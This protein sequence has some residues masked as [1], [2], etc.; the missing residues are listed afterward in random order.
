MSELIVIA[1]PNEERAE[2]VR[3]KLLDL[4]KSYVI[5]IEDAV[6]A[7]KRED[8]HV[9]LNQLVNPT[10]VSAVSGGFWGTLIGALFLNPLIGAALGAAGGALAGAMTDIGINDD[11]MRDV[12]GAIPP[13]SAALF[14]LARSMTAD[15]V[16]DELRGVGG[17]VLRT[18]LDRSKEQAL[19]EA[20]QGAAAAMPRPPAAPS[21]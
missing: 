3:H 6:V 18:S 12:S 1:F 20:L 9:K 5:S 2:Q 15:R 8:G 7:V 17:T 14:V 13:G 10:T 11:F 19:R 4:Q 21:A 16:M